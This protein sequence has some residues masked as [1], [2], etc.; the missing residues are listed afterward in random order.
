MEPAFAIFGL[1]PGATA[2]WQEALLVSEGVLKDRAHAE[3]V[4]AEL[5]GK[6]GCTAVRIVYHDGAAPEFGRRSLA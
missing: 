6:H 5:E 1:P 2:A 3:R 4:K